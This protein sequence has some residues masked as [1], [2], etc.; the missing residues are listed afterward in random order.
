MQ[1]KRVYYWFIISFFL[2]NGC[3]KD[4]FS[5]FTFEGIAGKNMEEAVGKNG[6]VSSVHP[7]ASEVGINILKA[8]GNA[9]D[10]A[11]ATGLAL[12]VVDQAN[13]GLGGGAFIVIH[14]ADGTVHTLDGREMAPSRAHRDMYIKDGKVDSKLSRHGPLAVGVP[15]VPA[16]Y[17][18]AL[19]LAGTMSLKEVINPATA[20]ARDGFILDGTYI[21]RYKGA[22]KN[23]KKDPGSAEVYFNADGSELGIEQIFKQPLLADTYD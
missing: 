3:A 14:L 13:C 15:G 21:D 16:A 8:G 4:G 6:V 11:I 7:L 23:L 5:F 10:A 12:G 18:K 19:E 2:F 9:V 20:I 17:L 1:L 22:V